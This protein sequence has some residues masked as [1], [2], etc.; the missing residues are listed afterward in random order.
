MMCTREGAFLRHWPERGRSADSDS[1]AASWRCGRD[2]CGGRI[3]DHGRR[4]HKLLP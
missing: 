2:W 4:F 3:A 1:S